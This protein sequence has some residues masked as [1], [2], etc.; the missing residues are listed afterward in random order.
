MNNRPKTFAQ[1]CKA[2][3]EDL[4]ADK[5]TKGAK[6]TIAYEKLKVITK[7]IN[8]TWQADWSNGNQRKWIVYTEYNSTKKRLV[9]NYVFFWYAN[10]FVS[11]RL[12]F[13]TKEGAEYAAT[14]FEKLYHDFLF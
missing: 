7:A 10:A 1:A 9:F 6:D 2:T 4:K 3:G 13:E 12:C 14:T 11:S 8:G 5:F